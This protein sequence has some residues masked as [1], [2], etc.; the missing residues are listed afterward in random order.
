MTIFKKTPETETNAYAW[1]TAEPRLYE[2]YFIRYFSLLFIFFWV[3]SSFLGYESSHY[4]PEQNLVINLLRCLL[5]MLIMTLTPFWHA[6]IVGKTSKLLRDTQTIQNKLSDIIDDTEYQTV[7]KQLVNQGKLPPTKWQTA[8]MIFIAWYFISEFFI[9]SSFVRDY[10]LVWEPQWLQSLIEW[11]IENTRTPAELPP[12][13]GGRWT[14]Y[15]MDFELLDFLQYPPFSEMNFSNERAFLHSPYG[16]TIM[17]FALWRLFIVI[18]T[19]TAFSLAFGNMLGWLGLNSLKIDYAKG[20]VDF[21]GRVIFNLLACLFYVAL[22]VL[23]TMSLNPEEIIIPYPA[24]TIFMT[25]IFA[26]LSILLT[27]SWF[28]LL[29]NVFIKLKHF[30]LG[31]KYD[32]SK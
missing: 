4:T 23:F 6:V 12:G 21:L 13:K 31:V 27:F 7:K 22:F 2:R 19:L 17:T 3:G 32:K 16:H 15:Y 14:F 30:L 8:A 10:Q 5:I 1:I 26:T 28:R 25:Y 9:V 11:G 18:P 29:L 24:T 20:I